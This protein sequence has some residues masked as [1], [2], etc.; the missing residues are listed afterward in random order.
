[1][2][3]WLVWVGC[4]LG[5]ALLAACTTLLGDF[6]AGGTSDGGTGSTTGTNGT[7]GTSG[8]GGE[9]G[10]PDGTMEAASQPEASGDDGGMD[11]TMPMDQY[12]APEASPPMDSGHPDAS[13]GGHPVEAGP[14]HGNGTFASVS[15]LTLDAGG[16]AQTGLLAT[17]L[18][19]DGIPDLAACTSGAG[20]GFS[21]FLSGGTSKMWHQ[22][23]TEDNPAT[24]CIGIASIN[25]QLG[26]GLT[27]YL[28][29]LEATGMP[30]LAIYT[31]DPGG[32]NW[33]WYYPHGMAPAQVFQLPGITPQSIASDDFNQDGLADLAVT[34]SGAS[35]Q[36]YQNMG[37]NGFA[38]MV[39]GSAL[40]IVPTAT[41]NISEGPMDIVFRDLNGDKVP[42]AVFGTMGVQ[43]Y[44]V[45]GDPTKPT[46]FGGLGALRPQ[47]GTMNPAT[48]QPRG[49]TTGDF[50][51]DG[52]IDIAYADQGT[53]DIAVFYN[54]GQTMAGQLPYF[55]APTPPLPQVGQSPYGIAS[56]DFNGD[57]L[58]DLALSVK[59]TPTTGGSITVLLSAPGRRFVMPPTS[60]PLAPGDL[61]SSIVV[62]D[63]NADKK[64]DIAALYTTKPAIAIFYGN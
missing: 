40:N 31:S 55:T 38:G 42:D 50:D 26:A 57:G 11:A 2:R 62:G 36:T 60:L 10:V 34:A 20:S 35:F 15:D 3:A 29:I 43:G 49:V 54:N 18:N 53:G 33:Y 14:V 17:D 19:S 48:I 39:A 52:Y 5:I 30:Q 21:V 4:A 32:G 13:D 8:T 46:F 44:D 16:A 23:F 24:N 1:M 58:A 61:T 12:V 25:L 56:A 22:A 63:F 51:N 41:V 59:G 47:W 64:Q 9:V 45:P 7:N 6:Q 37:L 27:P 28:A